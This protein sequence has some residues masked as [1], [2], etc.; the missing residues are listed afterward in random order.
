[1]PQGG[2]KKPFSGKAK[3]EQLKSKKQVKGGANLQGKV[4]VYI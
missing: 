4:N 3:K 2:R 1:M